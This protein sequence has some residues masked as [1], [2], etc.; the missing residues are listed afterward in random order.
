MVPETTIDEARGPN[1]FFRDFQPFK[2]GIHI[3]HVFERRKWND[4]CPPRQCFSALSL[5]SGH[6]FHRDPYLSP[7]SLKGSGI[8]E[9]NVVGARLCCLGE[10]LS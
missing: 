8:S 10:P 6:L 9:S 1:L 4:E 5:L 7:G 2:N 3:T